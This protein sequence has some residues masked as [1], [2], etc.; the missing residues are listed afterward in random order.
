MREQLLEMILFDRPQRRLQGCQTFRRFC[1]GVAGKS[2][3]I[4][5]CTSLL[6]AEE[7][8]LQELQY[9]VVVVCCLWAAKKMGFKVILNFI[10]GL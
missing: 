6:S 4:N 5:G 2:L 7:F 1:N 10:F 3:F 8:L 9:S